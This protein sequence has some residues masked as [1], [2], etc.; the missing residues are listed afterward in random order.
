[1][2]KYNINI[3]RY[4]DKELGA[5]VAEIIGGEELRTLLNGVVSEEKKGFKEINFPKKILTTNEGEVTYERHRRRY[6][7]GLFVNLVNE[8]NGW[9]DFYDLFF[10]EDFLNTGKVKTIIAT[11]GAFQNIERYLDSVKRLIRDLENFFLERNIS[12]TITIEED[13]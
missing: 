12:A 4:Y 9:N 6:L 2:K 7:K 8:T 1:M 13:E 3:K 11:G 10:T 5:P